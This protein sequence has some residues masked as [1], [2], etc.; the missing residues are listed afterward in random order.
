MSDR[1]DGS[2]DD[3]LDKTSM[4]QRSMVGAVSTIA[5]Q[6]FKVVLQFG[7]TVI[8]ARFLAPAEFGIVAMAMPLL[9]LAAALTDL[10]FAQAIMQR[11]NLTHAQ[12][13]SLFW[14]NGMVSAAIAAALLVSSPL[15]A[16]LYREPD[17]TP[18]LASL[19]AVVLLNGL[20]M[21]PVAVL[22]RNMR[23]V[24]LTVA[25]LAAM[26]VRLGVTVWAAWAGFSYWSLVMGQLAGALTT[27]AGA[28]LVSG[29]LPSWPKMVEGTR[30]IARF[31]MNLTG[32]SLATFFTQLADNMIVGA[33]AGK[34]AIGLFERSHTLILQSLMQLLG[35][36]G[37]VALPLLARVRDDA[38]LYRR[39]FVRM[40]LLCLWL[41]TPV[42]LFCLIMPDAI[43]LFL[44]GERWAE[45]I[46]ILRFFAVWGLATPVFWL[47]GWLYI[48]EG[49]TGR[50]F[51]LT[52][53][54]ALISVASFFI[55][56][57]WGAFGVVLVNSITYLLLQTPI[58][59]WGATRGG[60]VRGRDI[61]QALMAVTPPAAG[62]AAALIVAR[63]Y[64]HGWWT[65][66]GFLLAYAVFS[67]AFIAT[68]RGRDLFA[69]CWGLVKS[70]GKSAGPVQA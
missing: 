64:A 35:P 3:E 11:Q 50:Q 2:I 26:L 65:L 5:T 22:L 18:V 48:T 63:P 54:T 25:D 49:R 52:A 10:G 68:P 12:V 69:F 15:V 36:I 58:M 8:L 55:G 13:S 47:T 40:L 14:L 9:A 1:R 30:E 59:V 44:W 38:A 29:W 70:R 66:G 16:V 7:S 57:R 34:V 42:M 39:T 31:G 62:A 53:I 45:A 41:S 43:I 19:S 51:R 60:L 27:M 20:S 28:F 24:Q 23:F 17:V 67:L 61:V 46:P 37:R 6:L 33:L 21:A 4:K 32:V 56:V